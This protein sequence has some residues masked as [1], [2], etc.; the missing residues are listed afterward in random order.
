MLLLNFSHPLTTA[1]VQAVAALVGE[2]VHVRTIAAAFDHQQPFAPQVAAL[3]DAAHL[4]PEE[5]Q[6]TP[7]LINLP[8]YAPAAG[9][10]LAEVHGR[11]GH[12]PGLLRLSP[13]G[14]SVLPTY[15]VSEIINLQAVRA[16]ARVRRHMDR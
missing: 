3:A 6:T 11:S 15:V 14:S 1:Q 8:G 9:C 12:F 5:W 7:L 2:P 4:A 16:Q 13:A 10:L